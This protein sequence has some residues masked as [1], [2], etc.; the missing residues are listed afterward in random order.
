MKI[1]PEYIEMLKI[2]VNTISSSHQ[3]GGTETIAPAINDTNDDIVMV[4]NTKQYVK[5]LP[6][7]YQKAI[8]SVN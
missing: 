1:T 3:D 6:Q 8:N 4:D 7:Q 5:L 2:N